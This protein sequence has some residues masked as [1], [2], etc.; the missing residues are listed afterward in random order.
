MY[1]I[2]DYI[3]SGSLLARNIA[4]ERQ[5]QTSGTIASGEVYDFLRPQA[6]G[7]QRVVGMVRQRHPCDRSTERRNPCLADVLPF[8]VQQFRGYELHD[9]HCKKIRSGHPYRHL[10]HYGIFRYHGRNATDLS[11]RLHNLHS[12]RHTPHSSIECFY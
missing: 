11:R 6:V 9:R 2:S 1:K 3:R 8:A 7:Q 12:V 4:V 5:I 10:R